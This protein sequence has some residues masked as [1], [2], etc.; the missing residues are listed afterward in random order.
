MFLLFAGKSFWN[1][2]SDTFS[3]VPMFHECVRWRNVFDHM[4]RRIMDFVT[5]KFVC[6]FHRNLHYIQNSFFDSWILYSKEGAA[7]FISEDIFGWTPGLM[8][9]RL[10]EDRYFLV[11]LIFTCPK[12]L[13]VAPTYVFRL[14]KKSFLIFF[15]YVL[16]HFAVPLNV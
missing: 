6:L 14:Q 10:S 3:S 2:L 5:L 4:V 16:F 15:Y 8:V 9:A 13:V 7:R 11:Y 12:F 1:N